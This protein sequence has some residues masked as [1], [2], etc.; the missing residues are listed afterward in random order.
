MAEYKWFQGLTE[1]MDQATDPIL[2]SGSQLLKNVVFDEPGNISSRAGS[3]LV[4]SRVSTDQGFGLF[5]YNTTDGLH[6]LFLV[7]QR[8]LYVLNESTG[9]GTA[10]DTDEWTADKRVNGI[11]FLNRCYIGCESGSDPLAYTT[12]S[13]ITDVV[14]SIGGHCLAVNKEI[15]AVGGNSLLPQVIF[16]SDP[17]TD[18]FW[19]ATG[20]CAANADVGG[21]NFLDTTT[22]IFEADIEGAIIY[23]TTDGAMVTVVDWVSSTRIKTDGSTANWDND[24]IYVMKNVFKQD[25]KCTGIVSFNENFVSFD[26]HNMYIWDPTSQWSSKLPTFGCVNERTIVNVNGYLFWL[27]YDAVYMWSGEGKPIDISAKIK[28]KITGYGL[29][30]LIDWSKK[31][32]FAAGSIESENKYLLS[33][34]T[35]KTVS[36]APASALTNAVF[37]FDI[38]NGNW[39]VRSYQDQFCAFT[40]FINSANNR[41][42]YATGVTDAAV[43]KLG[44]GTVDDDDDATGQSIS[45]EIIT[46]EHQLL[47]KPFNSSQVTEYYVKYRSSSTVT[48]TDSVDRGTFSTLVTLPAASSVSTVAIVPSANREGFTH[49]LKF[50]TTG[51]FT[52]EGYG[53]AYED[54]GTTRL[55]KL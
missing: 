41:L 14:P 43:W 30:E 9:W 51:T 3:D 37:T 7:T 21:T 55:A 50:V 11:D 19:S 53:F 39:T 24:T 49:A 23:N 36:G 33:V 6:Y 34:G 40:D 54:L 20:T 29:W 47:D 16:Y 42:L 48:V 44:T 4:G 52:L 25:G 5:D 15:L 18:N 45:V 10:I 32:N 13:A 27:S 38:A 17:F 46:P 1:G 31:Y 22:G 12:G 35:L 28:N 8:D 2:T 26:E